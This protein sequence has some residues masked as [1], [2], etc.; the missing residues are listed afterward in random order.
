MI[1]RAL[2]I[3]SALAC[4]AVSLV[5]SV[6]A[7]RGAGEAIAVIAPS[8][9]AGAS[10]Q[11]I[12]QIGQ[13]I[14]DGISASGQF[15]VKGGGPIH[16]DAASTG[17]TLTSALAAGSRAQAAQILLTDVLKIA[18][19]KVLYRMTTYRISP[20]AFGRSQVFQQAYP[21]KD[22]RA[23]AAQ[24]ATDLAALEAP[25]TYTGTIYAVGPDGVTSDT[26]SAN[27][28]HLGQRFNVVRSGKKVAEAQ[29]TQITDANAIVSISN[30]TPNYQAAVGDLLISQEPGPAIPP[31]ASNSNNGALTLIGLLVGVGAAL[32]ALGHHG[33]AAAVNCPGPTPS[34]PGCG[35]PSPSPSGGSFLVSLTGVSS[36]NSQ[37]P[38]LTFT[39]SQPVNTAGITFNTT[40]FAFVTDQFNP[41]NQVSLQA[42]I[43][44]TPTF[45]PTGTILTVTVVAPLQIGDAYLFNFTSSITSTTAVPLTPNQFRYPSSGTIVSAAK[46]AQSAPLPANNSHGNG[47]GGAGTGAGNNGNH[48][49]ATPRPG[50]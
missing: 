31:A 2:A 42:L 48:G 15:D 47:N 33:E 44:S 1:S 49:A 26:G 9:T 30:P 4:I 11:T 35:T 20:V 16:V 45:D 3:L 36:P 8:N 38:T 28:F 23:F 37:T 24:F 29:I 14:Y 6:P 21:V 10:P 43:G 40:Q 18:D 19:G 27:G 17:D 5:P 32:L 25:R 22:A 46:H 41:A 7:A 13:S 34:G 39:F 12:A 50:H